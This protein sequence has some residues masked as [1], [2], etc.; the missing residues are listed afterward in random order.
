MGFSSVMRCAVLTLLPT[1]L[2]ISAVDLATSLKITFEVH[3]NYLQT[4]EY[5]N[6]GVCFTGSIQLDYLGTENITDKDWAIHFSSIR[7]LMQNNNT[8]FNITHTT[9]DNHILTPT[10]EFLGFTP[11]GS[12]YVITSLWENYMLFQ[13]DLMPRWFVVGSDGSTVVVENTDTEDLESYSIPIGD[14]ANTGDN[15][16]K[17]TDGNRFLSNVGLNVDVIQEPRLRIIPKPLVTKSGAGNIYLTNGLNVDDTVLPVDMQDAITQHLNRLGL[18]RSSSG[19]S[20]TI[21]IAPGDMSNV[22]AVVDGYKLI[23]AATG[24]SVKAFDIGGAFY[25]VMS[26]FGLIHIDDDTIPEVTI[27][28]APRFPVRGAF[29]DVARNFHS[30]EAIMRIM[31][32]MAAY[33]LNHFHIHLSDDEGFR[34]EIPTLPELTQIGSKRCYDPTETTCL[35]PQLGYGPTVKSEY[36]FYTGADFMELLQYA[37]ARNIEVIPEFDMPGHCRAAVISMRARQDDTYRL[38][39]PEDT[40]YIRTVQFYGRE[41]CLNPCVPGSTN[42]IKEVI[43]Q[44]KTMYTKSNLTMKSWHFGGDEVTNIYTG[45]GYAAVNNSWKSEPFEDSPACQTWIA[46]RNITLENITTEWGIEVSQ[47]LESENVTDMYAW[48]DGFKGI[49]HAEF[50]TDKTLVNLWDTVFWGADQSVSDFV[51]LGH[52]VILSCP[53]FLYFDMPHER[54]PNERGYYWASRTSSTRKVFSFA[55]ENL[56]QTAEYVP[57]YSGNP[58]EV[59]ASSTAPTIKGIQGQ[60]WSETVRTDEEL[61]Y[62]MFPRLLALAER[63]WHKADWELEYVPLQTYN[64]ET[65][66]VDKAALKWDTEEFMGVLGNRELAKVVATGVTMYVPP[67]GIS[68]KNGIFAANIDTAGIKIEV[69]VGLGFKPYS[70]PMNVDAVK[71]QARSYIGSLRSRVVEIDT[72]E[73]HCD[74]NDTFVCSLNVSS[75]DNTFVC[76]NDVPQK[77]FIDSLVL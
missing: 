3:D 77:Y 10:A 42:W 69:D 50:A 46:A 40:T 76:E 26:L 49:A 24:S 39:D 57:Q 33:K 61:G 37:A 73:C 18:K 71:I 56:P 47:F 11:S 2:A 22:T 29:V 70:K 17:A 54:N 1:A 35:S 63:A 5:A 12:P 62:M 27:E 32:N 41:S 20:I 34:L 53:D 66:H 6:Y 43:S 45:A 55:P 74:T 23:V 48:N 65:N 31:D 60:V 58:Y 44:V 52:E 21:E 19:H 16:T 72:S 14:V 38:D 30:K 15:L 36:D 13:T 75:F 8:D 64:Q 51:E 28:D 9:G 25:G 67:P 7:M 4:C 59:N 68:Y